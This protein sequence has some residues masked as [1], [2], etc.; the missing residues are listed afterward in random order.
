MQDLIPGPGRHS[1]TEP[2]RRPDLTAFYIKLRQ[3][4]TIV[5]YDKPFKRK[6][7]LPSDS[8][9]FKSGN[10]LRSHLVFGQR[11]SPSPCP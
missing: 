11:A 9:T 6:E 5:S 10:D 4:Q 2:P 1:T 8:L 7:R 3:L